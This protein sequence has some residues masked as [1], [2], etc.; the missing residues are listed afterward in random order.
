MESWA[1]PDSLLGLLQRGRGR[2][3]RLALSASD[4]REHV[5]ACIADDP[6]WW[7]Q[8]EQRGEYLAR[9]VH[10]LD[11]P[12]PELPINPQDPD[13]LSGIGFPVL[14]ELSRLGSAPAA[15]ILHQ[16]LSSTTDLDWTWVVGHLWGHAGAAGRDGL[17]ELTLDRLDDDDLAIAL[18]DD[19]DGPWLAWRD[20]PRVADALTRA[21][22]PHPHGI[23]DLTTATRDELLAAPDTPEHL[24]RGAT[25]RELAARGDLVLLDLAEREAARDRD[26]S[27][28]TTALLQLGPVTLPRAR[29]W[30]TGQDP[31]LQAVGRDLVAA[32]GDATDAPAVLEWFDDAVETGEWCETEDLAAGLARLRHQPALASLHRAWVLTPHSTARLDY[33][34]ALI[35]LDSAEL[36][37]HLTEAAD[38]CEEDVRAL[39]HY[40]RLTSHVWACSNDRGGSH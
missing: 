4:A 6:R 24:R 20:D 39:A 19:P 22:S 9:L 2:G 28:L 36:D 16:H 7:R 23:P 12:V 11:I 3:Y 8:I 34:H 27:S 33:L 13:L 32:H 1:A 31:W 25:F 35:D 14:V 29:S 38:D 30:I 26:V 15:A 10:E 18:T 40:A 5:L 21:L 37:E 17:R